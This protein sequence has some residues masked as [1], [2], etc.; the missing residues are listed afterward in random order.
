MRCDR[1]RMHL[2][3]LVFWC[4]VSVFSGTTI[5]ATILPESAIAKADPLLISQSESTLQQT[6]PNRDRFLQPVPLPLPPSPEEQA[7]ILP[8]PIPKLTPAQPAI[9]LLVRKIK[10]TGSTIFSSKDIT[11]I[12]Q[13]FEGRSLT[14]EEL[15]GVANAITQLYLNQ[16]Y[17]TSR[18]I[19]P[20]QK[21]TDGVV[22]I[23]VIEG[24][25]EQIE[26]EGTRR[27]NPSYLSSRI[28]LGSKTPLN[29][30]QLENQLRLLRADPLFENVEASLRSGSKLGQSILTVRVKEAN[31]FS[32]TVSIDNYSPPSVG[33][34]RVGINLRH[35]NLTG[36]GDEI[37]GSYYRSLT[38]GSNLYDFSYRVPLNPMNGTLQLRIAPDYYRIT[39]SDF[40]TF[41]IRGSAELYELSY[42]Q[43]LVRSPREE[44]ALSL[45]FTF[46]RFETLFNPFGTG[47]IPLV[48]NFAPEGVSRTSVIKFAQDY[49][50]RDSQGTWAL[51]SQFNFGTGLFNATI[52]TEPNPDGRFFSWQTQVQRV[53]VLS[54][55][56]LL[57]VQADLQLTP[58][59]LLP[60][61]QFVIG[62]GQSLR[63]YRQNVRAGDNGV[64]LSVEDRI[65][66]Q[67]NQAGIPILEVAPFLDLGTVWN[68]SDN[69]NQLPRQRFL[70]STGLGVLW[71]PLPHLNLR[72]D[73][74]L[75][76]TNLRDRG[77]NA[78]DNGFYFS[79]SYRF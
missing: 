71:E 37:A 73:Y 10:V 52:N 16:G 59:S 50:I 29:E 35:R 46:Q 78:Q 56:Q 3:S 54:R 65:A 24:S 68:V 30:D 57:I 33:S 70:A 17:I 58:N 53:Q 21:I 48:S 28:R 14:L 34:E 25:L 36:I 45:G 40:A 60:S 77:D 12:I 61:Q 31:P 6:D 67:R 63:G 64:R 11:P 42:R 18:A 22:Q 75:P 13:R 5:A 47:E 1:I 49:V 38:G 27:V 19:L 69:P 74:G 44:F 66:V 55:D 79:A 62:G 39:D 51:R 20:D 72:L 32:S 76:L 7:P 4:G 8:A 43:P 2:M 15:R 41:G 9:K 23:R 26:V